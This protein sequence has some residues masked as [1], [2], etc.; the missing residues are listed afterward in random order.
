MKNRHKKLLALSLAS[1]CAIASVPYSAPEATAEAVTEV[2]TE[3]VTEATAEASE[4]EAGTSTQT[5]TPATEPEQETQ[6]AAEDP[7]V[8]AESQTES[9]TTATLTEAGMET[10][11][12]QTDAGTEAE[13]D[14]EASADTV[15]ESAA[16]TQSGTGATEQSETQAA[17]LA[18][19]ESE[20]ETELPDLI[21]AEETEPGMVLDDGEKQVHITGTGTDLETR[22]YFWNFD[23]D[24]TFPEDSIEW[25]LYLTDP[26]YAV[27]IDGLAE[28]SFVMD[29]GITLAD[30]SAAQIQVQYVEE[31]ENDELVSAYLSFTLPD[32]AAIDEYLTLSVSGA[33]ETSL[34]IETCAVTGTDEAGDVIETTLIGLA[35]KWEAEEEEPETNAEASE[36][37]AAMVAA[38][39]AEGE[40]EGADAETETVEAETEETSIDDPDSYAVSAYSDTDGGIL[41]A[42]S[43]STA[44]WWMD[45][46][47]VNESD[48][49]YVEETDDFTLKYQIEF[50]TSEELEAEAVEIRIPAALYTDRYGEDKLP[51]DI[52]VPEGTPDDYTESSNSP[53]NWYLDDTAGELVFWNYRTIKSG[54][55]AS[56]QVLYKNIDIMDVVDGTAWSLTPAASVT[57]DGV[58]ETAEGAAMAGLVDTGVVLT[59]VTKSAY[60]ATGKSYTPALYTEG[61]VLSYVDGSLPDEYSGDSFSNYKYVVWKVTVKGDATQPWSITTEDATSLAGISLDTRVVGYRWLRETSSDYLASRYGWSNGTVTSSDE[62]TIKLKFYI[63]TA[64]PADEIGE[65]DELENTVTQTI[66]PADGI[67]PEQSLSASAEYTYVDYD[68]VYSGNVIGIDKW[69]GSSGTSR[70]KTYSAWLDIY[71][72][73]QAPGS[74]TEG[75]SYHGY[76]RCYGYGY[77]H[78][79]LGENQTG[80]GTA[81]S[82]GEYIPGTYYQVTTYDDVVYA[83]PNSDSDEAVILTSDD[84]YFSSVKFVITD[85]DYDV[86]EDTTVDA[87]TVDDV[88]QGY[89]IYAMFYGSDEWEQVDYIE[90]DGS[91]SLTYT[92]SDDDI[93]KEPYRVRAV[94]NATGYVTFCYF[95]IDVALKYD[96]PAVTA[97]QAKYGE[98][99][100]LNI[101]NICGVAGE[102]FTSS[103]SQGFFQDQAV[104]NG[105]YSEAG[106]EGLTMELYGMILMRDSAFSILT[107]LQ[108]Q[109]ESYKYGTAENDADNSRVLVDYY[110]TAY[111]GYI[112]SSSATKD[113][114]ESQGV[115]LPDRN[116]AVYYD[117]LPYGMKYN[118][119]AGVTA[120][121]IT[122]IS[123]LTWLT[124]PRAWDQTG[125]TVTVG[126]DDVIQNWNGTG[127][128]MVVF[129]ISYS[130]GDPGV[131][132]S[133]MWLQGYAVHFQAYYDWADMGAVNSEY[134]IAAYMP[135]TGDTVPLYGADDEVYCDDG[136]VPATVNDDYSPFKVGDINGDGV[137]D[138][139][140]VLYA[141]NLTVTDVATAAEN[142]IVKLVK[143][144]DD[145]FA[146]FTTKTAV[147]LS[148]GYTYEITVTNPSSGIMSGIVIFDVL[149]DALYRLDVS[150]E[151]VFEDDIDGSWV[152]TYTGIITEGLT[153][154]GIEAVIWYNQSR[155]AVIPEGAQDPA[156]VLTAANG[157]VIST[158]W[159]EDLSEVRAVAVD[160][161]STSDG[162][163]FT[164][165]AGGSV[166]FQISM[167][168]PD[169]MQAHIYA[170]NNPS[171]YSVMTK[172]DGST[173]SATVTATAVRVELADTGT[174]EVEKEFGDT[175]GVP[176][177]FMGQEFEFT[178]TDA[179]RNALANQKYTLYNYTG[180]EWSNS[181]VVL[182][183]DIYGKFTLTAGQKAVF[184]YVANYEDV[185]V[186]EMGHVFFDT[187]VEKD[188]TSADGTVSWLF[189]NTYKPVV[190]ATKSVSLLGYDVDTD[191]YTFTY[192]ITV[193]DDAQ[194]DYV[195]LAYSTYYYVSEASGDGITSEIQGSG[196]TDGKGEFPIKAGEVIALFPGC[197][198]TLYRIEE[199][200]A[201]DDFFTTA[202]VVSG[203][204]TDLAWTASITNIY[205][206]RYLTLTKTLSGYD[207]DGCDSTFTFAITDSNGDPVA[208]AYYV[209]LDAD[210]NEVTDDNGDVESG[211]TDADGGFTLTG[212]GS[213]RRIR[214]YGLLYNET[215][216]ILVS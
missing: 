153:S 58:E 176:D 36:A 91:G 20:A 100:E 160:I 112:V 118:A 199:V 203:T 40:T 202:S 134:N 172:Q 66:T 99:T 80:V 79:T 192:R 122:T 49:Y 35:L 117:L 64:Y 191:D 185:A 198:G 139:R 69:S 206:Y 208:D 124:Q 25:G 177:S 96:S 28:D 213:G 162:G 114:L 22:L 12:A 103:G 187:D 144:D 60:Y 24:D 130:G 89:Y 179:D 101:E 135:E 104:E 193:Y 197:I 37:E 214:I 63:V 212:A 85:Y 126:D 73:N 10:T 186:T 107:R 120:G 70:T 7:A 164:L 111:E 204:L 1:A 59:S 155:D 67:D 61:Q 166:S 26:L 83:Y 68:W 21:I 165:E 105:N 147:G 92:F 15:S 78:N 8:Q 129:H 30:G 32:G 74:D 195:P 119:S 138:I 127:R 174:I 210:G 136:T 190:F 216:T 56:F 3:A 42:D 113:L 184:P 18:D 161:S 151:T 169:T 39:A 170:Y 143:A 142:S 97:M 76:S 16:K 72:N 77:T 175:D 158:E 125:I 173:D 156:E 149:E 121:R 62:R 47:Y 2:V 132:S 33:D 159:T 205:K 54:S 178:L 106:L 75:F 207:E 98:L 131:Y 116:E 82:L 180:E 188:G 137:T 157:W 50:H 65:G 95:Y 13:T 189:T 57:V 27:E 53:F 34:F 31:M 183:T 46:Y 108:K 45:N 209:V 19:T 140:N 81:T 29:A 17:F 52:G 48:S 200:D 102:Q 145:P 133:G 84:Y 23:P 141:R 167:T 171:F 215:Y 6:I 44:L 211:Y 90:W 9:E 196:A 128:T 163:S 43:G 154:Q 110:L 201:T 38:L 93:A 11:A 123:G 181:G 182:A 71:E 146:S 41:L 4:A 168:A 194:E 115:S 51:D 14:P 152:G 94:H 5:E 86:Y 150:G 55:N 148:R 109:A 87:E 88:D